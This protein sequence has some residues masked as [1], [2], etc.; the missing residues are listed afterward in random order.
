M[1]PGDIETELGLP[2]PGRILEE[3]EWAR[4]AVK[5]LPEPGPLDWAAIFGRQAPLVL[6]LGCGNGRFTLGSALARPELNHFAI[7]VLPV[8]IRYA[9]RRANQRGLHNVRFAVKDAQT[10]LRSYVG[11]AAAAEMHLY[12]PQ[13]FHD[14]REAHRRVVTPAFVGDVHRGLAPGGLFV[15]Q[16]DNPDYWHYMT[17]I[18]PYFFVFEEHEGV[19]PDAPAGRSRR[20]IVA[21]QRGLHIFRGVGTRRDDLD[22]AEALELA[23]SLPEPRFRTRGP[24]IELDRWEERNR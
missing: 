19:W 14:P 8:V 22:H 2:I 7:D 11:D 16:T 9:T 20:E 15:V 13:P 18:L 21:R 10:F 24:W 6:D 1:Q 23:A 17:K 12:H 4:T 5:R 3:A